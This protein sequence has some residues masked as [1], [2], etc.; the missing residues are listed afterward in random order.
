MGLNGI[1]PRVGIHAHALN[2][3]GIRVRVPLSVQVFIIELVSSLDE[4][5]I[6]HLKNTSYMHKT[7][8]V[9]KRLIIYMM[10]LVSSCSTIYETTITK[11]NYIGDIVWMNDDGEEVKIYE[12]CIIDYTEVKRIQF[13]DG[14]SSDIVIKNTNPSL[15]ESEFIRFSSGGKTRMISGGMILIDNMRLETDVITYSHE[16]K[17]T[18]MK[19]Q[20]SSA[21]LLE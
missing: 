4:T 3:A 13:S 10:V 5:E 20:N 6:Y 17:R 16:N 21:S 15:L 18:S 9:M 1:R 12:N 7:D 14:T 19:Y 2:K 11:V 8:K